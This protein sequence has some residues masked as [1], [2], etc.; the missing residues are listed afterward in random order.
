MRQAHIAIP[1]TKIKY[2]FIVLTPTLALLGFA[3]EVADH[4]F[5]FSKRD[6]LI[7]LFNLAMECNIPN[8]Y[9]SALLLICAG[10]LAAIAM[11]AAA[12]KNAYRRH[13]AALALIFVYISIDE[14]AQLH[15]QAN[16]PLRHA[17]DV[18]GIFHYAWVIPATA[19]LLILA[20]VYWRFL[21][22]LPLRSRRLFLAAAACYIGG[23]LGTEFFVNHWVT[24]HGT[25]PVYGMLNVLQETMELTGLSIFI[26]ALL[27]HLRES[28]G[29]LCIRVE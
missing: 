11:A 7:R 4:L 1:L 19:I 25:D 17:L 22:A 13:W 27:G 5:G 18:D 12:E 6:T 14:T 20:A 28:I 23:A 16:R 26:V 2:G 24:L 3:T 8:W 10:L 9:A 21:W 15:E 29:E